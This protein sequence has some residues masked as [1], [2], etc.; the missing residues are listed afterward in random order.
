[1]AVTIEKQVE[2]SSHTT[3]GVSATARY[4]A[5]I[6]SVEALVEALNWAKKNEV[7]VLVLGG[8]SNVLLPTYYE[9]LVLLIELHRREIIEEDED[10]IDLLIGAGENW[11]D[12]VR[13]TVENGWD[14]TRKSSTYTG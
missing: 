14:G 3:M 7:A 6:G 8:G 13:W 12:L 9:G 2:L 1:M 4:V 10:T 11:H 5:R